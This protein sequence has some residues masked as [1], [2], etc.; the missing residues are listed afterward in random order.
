MIKRVCFYNCLTNQSLQT[1]NCI[2]K[3]NVTQVA[4][5]SFQMLKTRLN[6]EYPNGKNYPSD[7]QLPKWINVAEMKIIAKW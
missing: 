1:K 4:K 5:K 7:K 3:Q 6:G 2:G